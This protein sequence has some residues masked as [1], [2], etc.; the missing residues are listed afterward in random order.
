MHR[1]L[2]RDGCRLARVNAV[3][4]AAL[5]HVVSAPLDA[6]PKNRTALFNIASIF[7]LS[8]LFSKNSGNFLPDPFEKNTSQHPQHCP[9]SR[10]SLNDHSPFSIRRRIKRVIFNIAHFRALSNPNRKFFRFFFRSQARLPPPLEFASE[11][12]SRRTPA[13]WRTD[14][15]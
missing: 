9:I 2:Y 14:I 3:R 6:A 4:S 10:A 13:L 7:C 1:S 8:M 5:P 12:F 15:I 11:S